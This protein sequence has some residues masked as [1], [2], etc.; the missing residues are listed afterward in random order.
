MRK[1][2]G[3]RNVSPTEVLLVGVEVGLGGRHR[4]RW[5]TCRSVLS[6]LVISNK[7]Y[8][9]LINW[10]FPNVSVTFTTLNFERSKYS[11][12]YRKIKNH[13]SEIERRKDKYILD[14]VCVNNKKVILCR[15]PP[16]S[17]HSTLEDRLIH[18]TS[19]IFRCNL[20]LNNTFMRDLVSNS[21]LFV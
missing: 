12:R 1:T 17:T 10:M 19:F 8:N 6:F 3:V 11:S 14:M 4:V 5:E 2:S 7:I 9:L 16:K 18:H 20:L 21:L 13:L 15:S